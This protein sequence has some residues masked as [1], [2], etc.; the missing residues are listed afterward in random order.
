MTPDEAQKTLQEAGF[1]CRWHGRQLVGGSTYKPGNPGAF[2]GALFTLTL[3][4][5]GVCQVELTDFDGVT[6]SIT[7]GANE[8]KDLAAIVGALLGHLGALGFDSPPTVI[9]PWLAIQLGQTAPNARSEIEALSRLFLSEEAESEKINTL[10]SMGVWQVQHAQRPFNEQERLRMPIT[11]EKAP[12]RPPTRAV[13]GEDEPQGAPLS[14]HRVAYRQLKDGPRGP[15]HFDWAPLSERESWPTKLYPLEPFKL[16]ETPHEFDL[17]LLTSAIRQYSEM[18]PGWLDLI[19]FSTEPVDG[20][21][22]ACLAASKYPV[23]TEVPV[24]LQTL[25]VNPPSSQA[26]D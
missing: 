1:Y 12:W 26:A 15:L 21:V 18:L 4:E 14:I 23:A 13:F 3:L 16:L 5:P 8:T 20:R 24:W 11:G 19:V 7:Q 22:T 10:E 25:L 6:T 9:D 17:V 2:E